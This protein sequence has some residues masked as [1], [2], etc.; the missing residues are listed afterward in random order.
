MS[1]VQDHNNPPLPTE[2]ILASIRQILNED[3]APK[4]SGAKAGIVSLKKRSK[5]NR[6][7]SKSACTDNVLEL[8]KDMLCETTKIAEDILTLNN[9]VGATS[10]PLIDPE[11]AQETAKA[12]AQLQELQTSL[13]SA[14][15]SPVIGDKSLDQYT[16]EMMKPLLKQWLDA[17]LPTVVK[18]LVMEEIAKVAQHNSKAA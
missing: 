18:T 2:D 5:Q 12:F 11:I 17:N 1:R 14:S 7:Q 13:S 4:S 10:K 15:K 3:L 8:T 9:P 6:P 16:Q